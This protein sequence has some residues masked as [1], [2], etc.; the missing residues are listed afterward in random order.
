MMGVL[1]RSQCIVFQPRYRSEVDLCSMCGVA[2]ISNDIALR[3]GE[4]GS[5]LSAERLSFRLYAIR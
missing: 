1:L 4:G 5:I 2:G 3:D